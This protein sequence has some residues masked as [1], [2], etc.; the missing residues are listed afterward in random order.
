MAAPG[1]QVCC[2]DLFYPEAPL[3]QQRHIPGQGGGIAGDID[4]ALGRHPGD[5][6]DG[7]AVQALAGRVYGDDVRV[8]AL[9]LQVQGSGAGIGAEELGVLNAVAPGIVLGILNGL[10]NHLHAN[11]LSGGGGHGQGDGTHA[12]IEVQHQVVLRNACHGNGGFVEPLGLGVVHLVEGPGGQAE[13][14]A[15]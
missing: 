8:D 4:Q 2:R 3:L 6:F 1:E 15:A 7:V 12:A 10:G 11:D 5:G 9:L 13:I 14:Q